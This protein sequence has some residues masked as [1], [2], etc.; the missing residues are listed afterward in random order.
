MI[1]LGRLYRT[2]LHHQQGPHELPRRREAREDQYTVRMTWKKVYFNA[3][4]VMNGLP[5][6]LKHVF[7]KDKTDFNKHPYH[8]APWVPARMCSASGRPQL[9]RPKRNKD[10][11]GKDLKVR[12]SPTPNRPSI[13]SIHRHQ[14]ARVNLQAFKRVT[15]THLADARPV[16]R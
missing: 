5:I 10:Y 9:H 4:G 12:P 8:R 7:E 6:M 13:P 14:G 11:W 2:L 15:S 3:V 16:L 1:F